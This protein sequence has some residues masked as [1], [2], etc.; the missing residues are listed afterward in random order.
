MFV[1]NKLFVVY[2][3]LVVKKLMKK[4]K[5]QDRMYQLIVKFVSLYVVSI[6]FTWILYA[7]IYSYMIAASMSLDTIF[8]SICVILSFH[9]SHKQYDRL[10]MPCQR[11]SKLC[12][13]CY[14]HKIGNITQ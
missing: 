12:E 13:R 14:I 2:I 4:Q 10:C 7:T 1:T 11:L 5:R 3:K 9:F 8:N 6:I